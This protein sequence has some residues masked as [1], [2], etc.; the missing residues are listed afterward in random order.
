[1]KLV[2]FAIVLSAVG[3]ASNSYVSSSSSKSVSTP[4]EDADR[5]FSVLDVNDD[6][7][8][9][10]EE[11]R[12]GF[13]Y[14]IAS[15]DRGGKNEILAAKPGGSTE[16]VAKKKSKRRPT[17]QDATR[18]FETLF[19]KSNTASEGISK[20]EFKKMVVKASDNPD[21]DPFSAFY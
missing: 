11:A 20:E 2:L 21:T 5:L 18:A 9:S 19:E 14:L 13:Q 7:K 4:H 12:S 10:R 15:Y 1:M 3:C 17:N 6:G 16:S 8:I